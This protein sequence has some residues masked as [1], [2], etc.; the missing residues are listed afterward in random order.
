MCWRSPAAWAN[1]HPGFEPERSNGWASS[2]SPSTPTA[3]TPS[4]ATATSPL[5][6]RACEPWWSPLEKTY[7]S[8]A[9]RVWCTAPHSRHPI[10]T[11]IGS[12]Q[13]ARPAGD[14]SIPPFGF[15][16]TPTHGCWAPSPPSTTPAWSYLT[17]KPFTGGDGF[18]EQER[19][20][21]GRAAGDGSPPYRLEQAEERTLHLSMR[22]DLF[23]LAS[24]G[25][26][27]ALSLARV[28][29]R[30]AA[31]AVILFRAA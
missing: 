20:G 14:G 11:A 31:S 19:A 24:K 17:P 5:P 23:A 12:P 21:R 7:R 30:S 28:R 18:T 16:P 15:T 27:R 10:A 1:T 2:A 22:G 29:P 8:P 26:A 4:M 9:S 6:E 25:H 13:V 3:T